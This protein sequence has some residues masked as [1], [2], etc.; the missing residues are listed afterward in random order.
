MLNVG[1][2]FNTLVITMV[3]A[4]MRMF[5][6]GLSS[7]FIKKINLNELKPGML[8]PN[9]KYAERLTEKQVI[10]IKKVMKNKKQ[11]EVLIEETIPFAPF[12]FIGVLITILINGDMILILKLLFFG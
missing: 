5:L 3:Y 9:S 1:F 11:K 12:I 2:W 4:V 10:H 7:L 6:F 8:L